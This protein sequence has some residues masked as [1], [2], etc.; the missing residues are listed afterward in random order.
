[1]SKDVASDESGAIESD[2][3]VEGWDDDEEDWYEERPENFE[4]RQRVAQAIAVAEKEPGKGV[5]LLLGI[6]TDTDLD[7]NGDFELR[8]D[9]LA[10]L[11]TMGGA[12][13][14]AAMWVVERAQSVYDLAAIYMLSRNPSGAGDKDCTP[15]QLRSE[16]ADSL[17]FLTAAKELDENLRWQAIDEYL[18]AT[19]ISGYRRLGEIAPDIDIEQAVHGYGWGDDQFASSLRNLVAQDGSKP[20]ALRIEAVELLWDD[21]PSTASGGLASV[22]K[23]LPL[24]SHSPGDLLHALSRMTEEE[25][26][27]FLGVRDGEEFRRAGR[28]FHTSVLEALNAVHEIHP[29]GSVGEVLHAWTYEAVVRWGAGAAA[30]GC[31][32]ASD[33]V[34]LTLLAGRY[35]EV[36]SVDFTDEWTASSEVLQESCVSVADGWNEFAV[37]DVYRLAFHSSPE[38]RCVLRVEPTVNPGVRD[39]QLAVEQRDPGGLECF[40]GEITERGQRSSID[41]PDQLTARAAWVGLLFA[42]ISELS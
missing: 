13:E 12:A 20:M 8:S 4:D 21:S 24:G 31:L 26:E 11:C 14:R 38:V 42:G 37:G 19:G 34:A 9:A 22:M 5:P 32:D 41:L 33:K 16:E 30:N 40:A 1:M 7:E 2:V 6:L 18:G 17:A 23:D 29:L 15:E 39:W 28:R 10:H 25:V 3:L 35:A 27:T 36:R